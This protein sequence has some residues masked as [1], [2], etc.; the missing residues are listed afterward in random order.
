MF[1]YRLL[2]GKDRKG[3]NHIFLHI[4]TSIVIGMILI[5]HRFIQPS[6]IYMFSIARNQRFFKIVYF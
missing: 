6:H 1:A 3:E 2:L 5:K 4:Y